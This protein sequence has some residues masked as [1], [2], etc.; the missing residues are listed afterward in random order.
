MS[1]LF[2][3]LAVSVLFS[4]LSLA[5]AAEEKTITGDGVCA[6][7]ALK[8]TKTCQ[9]T[10]TA[11]EDGKKVTYYITHDAVSKAVHQSLGICGAKKDAPV[12]L[13]VT[14]TVKEEDGK[15]VITATKI[16]AAD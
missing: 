10:V 5:L 16:E 4:G 11:E 12:K 15:K 9:N 2:P 3:L 8:E 1:K 7:C 13:K 6:K 14:G